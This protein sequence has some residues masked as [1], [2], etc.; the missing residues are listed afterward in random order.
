MGGSYTNNTHHLGQ[1]NKPQENKEL[2]ELIQTSANQI[3]DCLALAAPSSKTGGGGGAGGIGGLNQSHSE[4]AELMERAVDYGKRLSAISANLANKHLK[5]SSESSKAPSHAAE[6]Q[7]LNQASEEILTE[8]DQILINEVSSRAQETITDFQVEIGQDLIV[9]F[10]R[11][12]S[13]SNNH[14]GQ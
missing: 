6:E 12:A 8:T 4:A 1:G 13:S 10:T 14:G 2:L 9:P 7:L 3:L 11:E 5:K